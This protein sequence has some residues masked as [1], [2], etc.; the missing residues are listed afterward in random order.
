MDDGTDSPSQGVSLLAA[1]GAYVWEMMRIANHPYEENAVG[2]QLLLINSEG[3][4]AYRLLMSVLEDTNPLRRERSRFRDRFDLKL[5]HRELIYMKRV[6]RQRLFAQA[7][8]SPRGFRSRRRI[9][10]LLMATFATPLVVAARR[11]DDRKWT[12]WLP[13]NAL[14]G[15]W[16][17]HL[18][19]DQP[20]K[21]ALIEPIETV[22]GLLNYGVRMA[23]A[24][25]RAAVDPMARTW[26]WRFVV[27]FTLGTD[28]APFQSRAFTLSKTPP[29]VDEARYRYSELPPRV[30]AAAEAKRDEALVTRVRTAS[31][32]ATRPDATIEGVRLQLSGLEGFPT[33]HSSY[34]EAQEC[35]QT[36]AQWVG[37]PIQYHDRFPTAVGDMLSWRLV[38]AP[39]GAR[40]INE[41]ARFSA[42]WVYRGEPRSDAS[43]RDRPQGEDTGDQR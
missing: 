40:L 16:G 31:A 25:T 5:V 10:T 30:R 19:Y 35:I 9:A 15:L 29:R 36:A 41:G 7:A 38:T 34:Y 17:F 26:V 37:S 28:D 18:V 39:S 4:E 20:T 43:H 1:T 8:R 24:I 22:Y 2:E 12:V 11:K 21:A 32:F 23:T 3:D 27:R 6:R 14:A 33:V 42:S 13:I